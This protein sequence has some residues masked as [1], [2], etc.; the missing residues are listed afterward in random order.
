LTAESSQSPPPPKP[1]PVRT[2]PRWLSRE[3]IYG[4]LAVVLIAAVGWF[5]GRV[6]DT[7]V[8]GFTHDDGVYAVAGKSLAEGKGFKLLHVVGQPGEIKYPFVYPAILSL[9]WLTNPNFPENLP[10]LN[11]ITIAFS[12]AACGLVYLYLRKAQRFP[13]WLSLLVITLTTA[14][15]FF[16]YFYS[17]IMSEGPYLFFSML[18]LM[19]AYRATKNG[20]EVS[21][22]DLAVLVALSCVTFLTRIP[23]VTLMGAIGVWLLIN[24]QWKNALRYGM[25][26]LA[27]GIMPWAL[28]VKYQTPE[29]TA[30]SYPLINAYSNYGLEF[31][32]NF[33]GTN[34]LSSLPGDFY[35]LFRSLLEQLF[36]LISNFIKNFPALKNS[37]S[38]IEVVAMII[39]LSQ[40]GLSGYFLMQVVRTAKQSCVK[41]SNWFHWQINPAVFSIPGLYLFFYLL[42]ITLWNYEDQLSRFLTAV[43]PLLWLYFF[44]PWVSYL[45][46]FGQPWP[47]KRK[48]GALALIGVLLTT[49]LS[50]WI[51]PNAYKLVYTSRNQH[52][53]EV[54][55]YRWM[56]REYQHVFAWINKSLPPDAPLSASSDVV[57]YLYTGH[58]TYYTFFAS[59]RRKNGQFTPDSIPLLMQ[60]LDYHHVKYLVAEPH[61]TGRIIREPVNVVAKQLLKA[62]PHRFKQV[63]G[64]PHGAIA[65]YK[66]LPL[67]SGSKKAQPESLPA[68]QKTSSTS[69]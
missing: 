24:G 42:M 28:W 40:Y 36:P 32:H 20:P 26:C 59:L 13:G 60:S 69:H 58:P 34:Y 47:A 1:D 14:H 15:F 6:V 56:W 55:R 68:H 39:L 30:M 23:G 4:L 49:T 61:M 45:P 27:F 57:F 17:S 43:V 16:I 25:G 2:W 51:A 31:F 41:G 67:E 11:Y 3:I 22:R 18:T 8:L 64:S 48:L 52:W 35:S 12:L 54:G 50:L 37:P 46:E 5:Y 62:F 9:V 66:I 65:I 44:K 19:M 53:V 38:A 33:T 63:Y 21:P 7:E 29:V 10:A